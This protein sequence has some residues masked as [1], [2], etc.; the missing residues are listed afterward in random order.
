MRKCRPCI[1]NFLNFV[2]KIE[3]FTTLIMQCGFTIHILSRSKRVRPYIMSSQ[4]WQFL[5][6]SPL[7]R[8]HSFVKDEHTHGK[9]M[10]RKGRTK[11]IYKGT[12]IS[13][14]SLLMQSFIMCL[15]LV[16]FLAI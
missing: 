12:F 3:M 1:H 7:S 9:K 2:Q 14:R 15:M 13:E 10:A 4:N 8:R 11:V 16:F 5:T 6:P